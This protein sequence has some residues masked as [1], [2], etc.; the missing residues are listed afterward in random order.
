ML[1]GF[2]PPPLTNAQCQ[3]TLYQN[4][5]DC[6]DS[7]TRPCVGSGSDSSGELLWEDAKYWN[8]TAAVCDTIL[9][10]AVLI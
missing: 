1:G 5:P 3:V 4:I 10:W 6:G 2:F 8:K 9:F 7:W